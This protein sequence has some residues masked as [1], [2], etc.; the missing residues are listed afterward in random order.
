MSIAALMMG[1]QRAL[2]ACRQPTICFLQGHELKVCWLM[3]VAM[4]GRP[5]L[6]SIEGEQLNHVCV[7]VTR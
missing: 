4:I 5:I 3:S 7:L 1:S 6:G 2:Q